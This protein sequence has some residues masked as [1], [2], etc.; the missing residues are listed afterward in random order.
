M[1]VFSYAGKAL[2][3]TN[4]IDATKEIFRAGAESVQMAIESPKR[5]ISD[6]TN[7]VQNVLMDVEQISKTVPYMNQTMIDDD[8]PLKSDLTTPIFNQSAYAEY[9]KEK[10]AEEAAMARHMA[11]VRESLS[12]SAAD[13]SESAGRR[14]AAQAAYDAG[15][16]AAQKAAYDAGLNLNQESANSV[17]ENAN[18]IAVTYPDG[19]SGIIEDAQS[20]SMVPYTNQRSGLNVTALLVYG[21]IGYGIYKL[22]AGNKKKGD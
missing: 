19:T 20:A 21:L 3:M 1:S 10:A 12:K 5:W 14:S 9:Q 11:E 15:I 22:I 18:E 17:I 4:P 16:R 13:A 2:K 6:P 7:L 8:I